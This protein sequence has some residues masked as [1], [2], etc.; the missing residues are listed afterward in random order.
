MKKI[1][2]AGLLVISS[3]PA[4]AQSW[5]NLFDGQSLVGWKQLNGQAKYRVEPWV[6]TQQ[7]YKRRL[8]GA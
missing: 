6:L 8:T 7:A 1:I 5:I 4:I 3:L 2:L